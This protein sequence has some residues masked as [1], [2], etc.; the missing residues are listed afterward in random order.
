M[1]EYGLIQAWGPGEG[2]EA[3]IYHEGRLPQHAPSLDISV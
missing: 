1:Q 2:S 3:S